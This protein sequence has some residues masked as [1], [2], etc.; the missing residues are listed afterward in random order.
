MKIYTKM[1]KM[2]IIQRMYKV[3]NHLCY[4]NNKT[5]NIDREQI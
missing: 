3:K 2:M 1:I 4:F 5:M